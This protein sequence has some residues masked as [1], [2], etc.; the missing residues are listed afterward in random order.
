MCY[1]LPLLWSEE[2][3]IDLKNID[4]FLI[5]SSPYSPS[6]KLHENKSNRVIRGSTELVFTILEG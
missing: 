4:V 6:T 1:R 3:E 2:L 5:K